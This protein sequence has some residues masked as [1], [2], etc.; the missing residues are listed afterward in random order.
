[1]GHASKTEEKET[2]GE[3]LRERRGDISYR[4]LEKLS[5]VHFSVIAAIERGERAA[6]G[7]IASKLARALNLDD[8]QR[9]KF[10]TQAL[11]TTQRER[12]PFEFRNYDPEVFRVLWG[13]LYKHD[14]TPSTVEKVHYTASRGRSTIVLKAAAKLMAHQMANK[15]TQLKRF[16][17]TGDLKSLPDG[18]VL[19][20]TDGGWA[21]VNVTVAKADKM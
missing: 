8:S 2:F 18:L 17:K 10:L 5:G 1:M 16:A 3:L 21:L 12:V 11:G 4:N 14:L 7:E 19:E 15:V 6:G 13:E 20:L 9:N